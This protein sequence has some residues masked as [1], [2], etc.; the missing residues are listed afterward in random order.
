M[1]LLM[2]LGSIGAYAENKNNF[3]DIDAEFLTE[4]D[5]NKASKEQIVQFKSSKDA[6]VLKGVIIPKG[7][8]FTGHIKSFKKARWAYRRAKVHIEIDKMTFPDGETYNVTAFT[9]KHN[10]KGAAAV[11]ILKGV[12]SFPF[13]LI[14][15]AAGICIITAEAVTIIGILLIGPTGY[16]FG[17]I[18]GKLSRG[19]NC[20][21]HPGDDIKLKI[22]KVRY[23]PSEKQD[24]PENIQLP[25]NA[26]K[27]I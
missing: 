2:N 10:L 5:V 20:R 13:A 22:K 3:K 26:S 6:E 21:K 27:N 4:L 25:V 24:E 11:N 15:G 16:V 12:I 7:T 23:A 9:K 18:T 8:V 1:L 14:T 17:R 19:I